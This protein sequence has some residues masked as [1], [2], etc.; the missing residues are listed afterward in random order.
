ML[1]DRKLFKKEHYIKAK[2]IKPLI[3]QK[4]F[5]KKLI[6]SLGGES[7]TGKTEIASIIQERLWNKH[8]IRCKTIH[9]DDYY[10]S[11]WQDRNDIRKKKGIK[12]V[13]INE[14]NW[15][16]INKITKTFKSKSKVLRVQR[17]H[18]YTNCI[19]YVKTDNQNI[20]ILLFE[21]LYANNIKDADIQIFLEGTY[22]QTKNFRK[23][24]KK[25]EQT[26]FRDRILQKEHKEI[27][28]LSKYITYSIPFKIKK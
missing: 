12:S 7:G 26:T 4:Y 25:E 3:M 1:G 5:H 27:Q 21:G 14:I 10:F 15:E 20:D 24:R 16:L 22:N 17:I 8:K 6:I 9:I 19:E 2:I 11:S 23:E 18:K 28:K 13:G